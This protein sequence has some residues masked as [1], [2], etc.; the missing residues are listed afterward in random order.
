VI[1]QHS[2]RVVAVA[3]VV[4]STLVAISLPAVAAPTTPSPHPT[5]VNAG[6]LAS[7]RAAAK[8]LNSEIAALD[9]RAE[10]A[11]EAYDE[12]ESQL[13]TVVNQ[14]IVL[15]Q[16]ILDE[17]N[18]VTAQQMLNADRASQLYMAGGPLAL[19]ASVLDGSNDLSDVVDQMQALQSIMNGTQA[20]VVT[21]THQL[22]NDT[23]DETELTAL[24]SQQAALS[25]AVGKRA[26]TVH[27]LLTQRQNALTQ[28]NAT[29]IALAA[30]LQQQ[31]QQA[32]AA[33]ARA[34]FASLQ[35]V[36]TPPPDNQW[37]VAAIE[38]ASTR[39][40]DPYVWGATG[41]TTF[42][43][44]GLVQWAYAQAGL[45]LP[46]TSRDQWNASRPLALA[47]LRPG[48]LLFYASDLSNPD[49]IHHVVM[50][51][52]GGMIIEAPHTGAYVQEVPVYLDGFIG[53]RRPGPGGPASSAAATP[54]ASAV[55]PA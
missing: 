4:T 15:E 54:V 5:T 39:I 33:A 18:S 42:D 17:R 38:A 31:Q 45:S 29:V 35:L 27:A 36:G 28:A 21:G 52:G 49:T 55:P 25:S 7:A 13:G 14:A 2:R 10:T 9:A 1:V 37:A 16:R 48:D 8:T 50:Y 30:Q 53:A 24:T 22:V 51:V 19:Y 12:A 44:S 40:G 46:R 43:C 6:D 34:Q 23:A 26:A 47:D 3:A 20:T 32:E 11:S 41:P